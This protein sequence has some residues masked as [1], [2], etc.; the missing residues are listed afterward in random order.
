MQSVGSVAEEESSRQAE[1]DEELSGLAALFQAE[2]ERAAEAQ[3]VEV[4]NGFMP[5]GGALPC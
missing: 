4:S 5:A 1:K 2:I 3:I